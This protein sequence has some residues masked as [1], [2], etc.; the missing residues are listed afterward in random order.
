MNDL[1]MNYSLPVIGV[2]IILIVFVIIVFNKIIVV[3]RRVERCNSMIDVYL[4]K[5]FDLIPNLVEVCKGYAKHEQETLQN[6]AMLRSSY[7]DN[8]NDDDRDKLNSIYDDFMILVEDNPD[9]KASE[10]FIKLQKEITNVENEI[11]AARRIHLKSIMDYNNIVMKFPYLVVAKIFGFHKMDQP[12]YEY[13]DV[14]V[15]F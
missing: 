6:V 15:K 2:L 7:N 9:L 5:R 4:K 14:K 10:N 3:K 1:L 13:K 8:P 11:Q 12:N